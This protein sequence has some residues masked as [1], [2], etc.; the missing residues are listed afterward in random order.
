MANI[1]NE[2][3]LFSFLSDT[4]NIT[5]NVDNNISLS[6]NYSLISASHKALMAQNFVSIQRGISQT[7]VGRNVEKDMIV[8]MFDFEITP[9][10]YPEFFPNMAE[11]IDE[12]I[13]AG[14]KNEE[15]RLYACEWEDWGNDVFDDWGF[16]YIYDVTTGKYYFPLLNPMNLDDGVITTQTFSAFNRTFV[17]NHGWSAQG[18]FKFKITCNDNLPFR[19]GA[20]GNMGSDGDEIVDYL[21]HNY[22]YNST[23]L[24][25]Y[26]NRHAEDGDDV[27]ILYSYVIPIKTSDNTSQT[28]TMVDDGSNMSLVTN[29]ITNGVI[30][31]F[32]KTNDVKEWILNDITVSGNI[33]S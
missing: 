26:Y 13:M 10:N 24:T 22:S 1:G 17:I 4:E 25:L 9:S 12:N 11:L 28:Y 5:A 23:N 16:F 8:E 27:E 32:S 18:I 19:F 3:E 7:I 2:T 31:Y 15:D 6:S 29:E 20:Y 14:D 33:I 30:V 21:S